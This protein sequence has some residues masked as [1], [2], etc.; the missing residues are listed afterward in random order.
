MSSLASSS[1]DVV[2]NLNSSLSIF[3][4]CGSTSILLHI[5]V[6]DPARRFPSLS[7]L[8]D[9]KPP[10]LQLRAWSTEKTF[11][12]G[13]LRGI[14]CRGILY[15]NLSESRNSVFVR[16]IPWFFRGRAVS[17]VLAPLSVNKFVLQNT[18][19]WFEHISYFSYS[20]KQVCKLI[21]KSF[22]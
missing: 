5:L 17:Q 21:F 13:Q 10:F 19:Y 20:P 6:S 8:P 7:C 2:C 18:F 14:F 3:V 22:A 16:F 15:R 9:M 1:V 12:C 4:S 11:P